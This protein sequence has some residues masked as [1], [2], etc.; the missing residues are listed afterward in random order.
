MVSISS[1][2]LYESSSSQL[3]GRGRASGLYC[4]VDDAMMLTVQAQWSFQRQAPYPSVPTRASKSIPLVPGSQLVKTQ[5]P[6]D[7]LP[8]LSNQVVNGCL[9]GVKGTVPSHKPLIIFG[10]IDKQS[11]C[12]WA[13]SSSSID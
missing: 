13:L 3:P 6:W 8:T 11:S 4:V 12:G 10:T 5:C 2:V 1:M 9:M 7:A